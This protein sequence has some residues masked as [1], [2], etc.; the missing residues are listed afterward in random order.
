MLVYY[1]TDDTSSQFYGC[2]NAA[3]ADAADAVGA[4]GSRRHHSAACII[5]GMR[6]FDGMLESIRLLCVVARYFMVCL[7][8]SVRVSVLL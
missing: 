3:G 1:H 8:V 5:L 4:D 7:C 6:L 2:Q